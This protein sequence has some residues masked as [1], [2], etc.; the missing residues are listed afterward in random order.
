MVWVTA[1]DTITSMVAGVV[2]KLIRLAEKFFTVT[3]MG[4]VPVKQARPPP[5][6]TR[7][8]IPT[9][10][11]DG[12]GAALK[13][14]APRSVGVNPERVDAS[15]SDVGPMAGAN[16]AS[17]EEALAAAHDAHP[18]L[19]PAL[20]KKIIAGTDYLKIATTLV[21]CATDVALP[22]LDIAMP[23]SPADLSKIYEMKERYGLGASVD[24]LIAALKW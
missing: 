2:E 16:V 22:K 13:A 4:C 1:P 18:A 8:V 12:A 17:T 5:G 11:L 9:S 24:R 19:T 20:A 21:H 7:F 15:K 10:I 23:K 14:S 6:D 3:V